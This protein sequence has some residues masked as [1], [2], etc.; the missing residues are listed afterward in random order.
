M[1]LDTSGLLCLHHKKAQFHGQA[2]EYY[3]AA[4]RRLTNNY[5]LA[6][7]I[8]L[9]TVRRLPQQATVAFVIDLLRNPG[10]TCTFSWKVAGS[11]SPCW[12]VMVPA[13][14]SDP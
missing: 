13:P 12:A 11:P 1:L 14:I 3:R 2:C 9:A 8:A 6:E 5:V 7:F 4:H 10:S